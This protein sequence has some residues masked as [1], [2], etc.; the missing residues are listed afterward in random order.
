[1]LLSRRW[2]ESQLLQNIKKDYCKQK[3]Y[4][5]LIHK[6]TFDHFNLSRYIV[7]SLLSSLSIYIITIRLFKVIHCILNELNGLV[8]RIR[9]N[10]FGIFCKKCDKFRSTLPQCQSDNFPSQK[11]MTRKPAQYP[12]INVVMPLVPTPF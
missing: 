6:S 7:I 11:D 10:L 5:K 2:S 1:M 12:C 9:I 8:E 3:R 4:F